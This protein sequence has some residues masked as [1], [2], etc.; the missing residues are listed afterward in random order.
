MTHELLIATT[1]DGNPLPPAEQASLRLTME[2]EYLRIE[3]DAPFVG[4]PAPEGPPGPTDGL[5]SF[6]VVEL[7]V[8]AEGERYTEIELS[9]HGHHWV[10]RLEGIRT[11]V[12]KGVPIDW[13]PEVSGGR[14]RGVARIVRHHLPAQPRWCNAFRIAGVAEARQ[15]H[16]CTPVPGEAPNFHR[17][18]QFGRWPFAEG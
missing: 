6:E 16:A 15:F 18:H 10:L 2:P 13:A 4:D 7:F 1:W 5:W 3:V 8:V 11:A 17:L 9:P 14:F 12:E